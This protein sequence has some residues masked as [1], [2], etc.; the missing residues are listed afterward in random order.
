MGE[1]GTESPYNEPVGQWERRKGMQVIEWNKKRVG[2]S[3]CRCSTEYFYVCSKW[4]P[5]WLFF[6]EPLFFSHPEVKTKVFL[7]EKLL[8]GLERIW[9]EELVSLRW[10]GNGLLLK[11]VLVLMG[12]CQ[13]KEMRK[14][15]K[16]SLKALEAD[17]QFA[18]TL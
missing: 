13:R 9:S 4:K 7:T 3:R 17:I 5:K 11:L 12:I 15:F 2:C 8:A 6:V 10:E 14:S 18:N 1:C 16:D